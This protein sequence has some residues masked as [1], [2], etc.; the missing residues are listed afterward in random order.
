[1]LE[2]KCLLH[3]QPRPFGTWSWNQSICGACGNKCFPLPRCEPVWSASTDLRPHLV[4]LLLFG[5][6][7]FLPQL[8]PIEKH[9]L[10]HA[11]CSPSCFA[12]L[13]ELCHPRIVCCQVHP[14]SVDCALAPAPCRLVPTSPC[15]RRF[16]PSASHQRHISLTA[17][18]YA[19]DSI[20]PL[21]E[22]LLAWEHSNRL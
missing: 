10:F 12:V 17:L 15:P 8:V 21:L 5:A 4:Q 6:D 1:M 20:L 9:V 7:A 14:C 22:G 19:D 16:E 18:D 13:F 11:R 2:S 3:S